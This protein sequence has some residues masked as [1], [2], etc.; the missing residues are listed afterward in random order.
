M[1]RR[2]RR[3]ESGW[4]HSKARHPRR[5]GRSLPLDS[6]AGEEA[7]L[8][9]H[10]TA[11][12][13]SFLELE[14][15]DPSSHMHIGW[16][17]VFDPLPGGGTPSIDE[18]RE[19]LEGRL[20]LLPRFRRRLSEPQTGGMS[21]PTWAEE[22]RFDISI[23]VRHATLP[24]PGEAPE[25][26]EWL[27]DFYSHRLDRAH[28]LWE[29]TLLDGLGEGRW[30]I[31]AKVHHCLVDGMSGSSVTSLILDAEPEPAPGSAGILEAFGT[32]REERNGSHGPLSLIAEG[33]RAGVD[34]ALHPR[35][36]GGALARSRSLAE[37]VRD[38]LRG[39]PASSLNVQIGAT[40]RMATVAVPLDEVKHVKGELGGTVNDVVLA[41]ATGGIRRLLRS[42][43]EE[44]DPAGLR[45]MVP[46]SLR[47]A[48]E[49]LALGNRVSSLFVDLPVSEA[50]PLARYRRTLE[51]AETLKEGRQAAGVE[52]FLD[53]AGVA[54]PVLHAT[55][56]RLAYTPRLFNVTI[57]NVRGPQATLYALGARLRRVIPMV[58]IFAY[59]AV[60]IAVAS[61]D[62]EVVF[63]LS[64]DRGTVSDLDVLAEGIEESLRE[65]GE[66]CGEGAA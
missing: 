58:P 60:G 57:T 40:R 22:D 53:L 24:R 41:A 45:A 33:A 36:L 62:G 2:G 56:A 42:R 54:P 32:G 39:A 16:A 35:K 55:L 43:G 48:S 66:L 8:A 9:D 61:Y 31:A 5:S 37:L 21:W 47:R 29:M 38:E 64:A 19:L 17:M 14:E 4:L 30:A 11:L 44:P 52:T 46:V 50:D 1:H 3:F 23:H 7:G 65:L 49:S 28:P 18:V 34:L 27:G 51:A 26:L 6:A 13:A 12:D 59:H 15:N 63:G 25:L 20:S 10:L